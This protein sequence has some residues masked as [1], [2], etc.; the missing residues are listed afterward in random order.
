[1]CIIL[2]HAKFKLIDVLRLSTILVVMI[3]YF[4]F[5][6][7]KFILPD[8]WKYF[9]FLY[10]NTIYTLNLFCNKGMESFMLLILMYQKT[11]TSKTI[12]HY[13]TQHNFC[14][15]SVR[16]IITRRVAN[17]L[18]FYFPLKTFEFSLK[19]FATNCIENSLGSKGKIIF[20]L[21]EEWYNLAILNMV[22]MGW[23]S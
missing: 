17:F 15:V 11:R 13:A 19:I 4:I 14:Y 6:R 21:G 9:H 23:T 22:F 5:I 20:V 12:T 2:L 16:E 7:V 10:H 8:F 3:Y 18:S 1:M